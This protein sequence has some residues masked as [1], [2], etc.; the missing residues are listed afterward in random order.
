MKGG[1]KM[2]KSFAKYLDVSALITLVT[3]GLSIYSDIGINF[4]DYIMMALCVLIL[5][6][7]LYTIRRKENG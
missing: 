7:R 1:N 5:G 2:D 6:L 3:I 4:V